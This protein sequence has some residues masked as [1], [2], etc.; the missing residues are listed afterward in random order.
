MQNVKRKTQNN[1]TKSEILPS[2][3]ER[4]NFSFCALHFAFSQRGFGL[5]EVVVATAM[6]TFALIAFLQAGAL[7]IRL[8]RNQKETL[9]A[10][11]LAEEGLEAVRMV[12]DASW[13]DITW[14]TETENP[15]LR[16]YPVV[17]NGAWV[18]ATT[19]PGLAG[20][21]HDRYVQFEKVS[22]DASDRIVI[23]GGT[24]DPGT[25]RVIAHAVSVAGDIRIETYITD[26]QQFLS[27][28]DDAVSVSYTGAATDD[29]GANFP[30]SNAGDGDPGQTFTTGAL[31][32][33]ITRV[34]LLLR[35]ATVQPS[36][37]F[38]ELRV[39]PTGVV[40]GTSQIVSGY[41]ISTTTPAWVN[42]HFFP[43]VPVSGLTIYTIR[44]RSIPDSTIPDSGSAGYVHWQYRQ[45]AFS[46]YP[47]GV[48]RRFIGQGGDHDDAGQ[49][50]DQYDFGFKVYAYP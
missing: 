23:S 29:I 19:S 42:F 25:H 43:T 16:Y 20:G 48:A 10:T 2:R 17:E 4:R 40:L 24:D 22:R 26:F 3:A 38:V 39:S 37:V 45:T 28:K 15:S 5:V 31:P 14:R 18:L 32:S 36:D 34:S 8:L 44:M 50:L 41:T 9:K 21:V 47:G 33:E 13:A 1:S 46:P 12:R 6:A 30:S 35:R 11:L 7:A 27:R 49:L